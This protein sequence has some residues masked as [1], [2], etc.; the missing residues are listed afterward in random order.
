MKIVTP[1]MK[2]INRLSKTRTQ[3]AQVRGFAFAAKQCPLCFRK[4]H[5]NSSTCSN[6]KPKSIC[7]RLAVCQCRLGFQAPPVLGKLNWQFS[8]LFR[9]ESHMAN[10]R[11][12]KRHK[13]NPTQIRQAGNGARGPCLQRYTNSSSRWS[14]PRGHL[15]PPTS[16]LQKGQAQ[17]ILDSCE[18]KLCLQF[19]GGGLPLD[20]DLETS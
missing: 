11:K 17:R 4:I 20:A 6:L 18:F 5:S 8:I 9:S 19:A 15:A 14:P 7:I 12:N 1:A 10:S 16:C 13:K 3:M 2:N